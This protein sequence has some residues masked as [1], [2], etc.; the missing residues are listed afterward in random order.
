LGKRFA[1]EKKFKGKVDAVLLD[2]CID[3]GTDVELAFETK[4]ADE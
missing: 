3:G 2:L 1:V 4:C